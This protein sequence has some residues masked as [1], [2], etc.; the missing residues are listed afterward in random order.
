MF[1]YSNCRLI[2]NRSHAT[3]C[4]LLESLKYQWSF[5]FVIFKCLY[6]KSMTSMEGRREGGRD[7]GNLKKRIAVGGR[8]GLADLH[9][10][11]FP[12]FFF[13]FYKFF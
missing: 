13:L 5:C 1:T 8:F 4:Y 10:P 6:T 11:P 9:K 7:D 3:P 2:I 12:S